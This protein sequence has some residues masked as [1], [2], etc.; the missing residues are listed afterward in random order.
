[1]VTIASNLQY[2]HQLSRFAH[3][4]NEN[5][6]RAYRTPASTLGRQLLEHVEHLSYTADLWICMLDDAMHVTN[7]QKCFYA[8]RLK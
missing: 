8:I 6:S 3:V 4:P 7:G 1:M 2:I 5:C